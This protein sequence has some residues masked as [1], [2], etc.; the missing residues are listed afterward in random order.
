MTLE[1]ERWGDREQGGD[2]EGEIR[3]D[4]ERWGEMKREKERRRGEPSRREQNNEQ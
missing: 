1:K 4:E 3:R 2:V